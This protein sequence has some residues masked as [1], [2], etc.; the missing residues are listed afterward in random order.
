[1]PSVHAA[2]QLAWHG[3]SPP[4]RAHMPDHV[5]ERG[6]AHW[7]LALQDYLHINHARRVAPS[8]GPV[9]CRPTAT[10]LAVAQNVMLGAARR[11][12]TCSAP[13]SISADWRRPG[14]RGCFWGGKRWGFFVRWRRLP[15]GAGPLAGW[16]ALTT[17]PD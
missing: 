5:G 13:P 11:P 8:A 17:C 6:A 10:D 7:N 1:M 4:R 3:F 16:G 2:S 12:A 14:G 15:A 9:R